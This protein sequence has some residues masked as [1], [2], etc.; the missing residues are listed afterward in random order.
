MFDQVMGL[1]DSP[2]RDVGH[3][4]DTDDILEAPYQSCPR[5][6]D[7]LAQRCERPVEL[8]LF[9]DQRERTVNATITKCCHEPGRRFVVLDQ[10]IQK[11][12]EQH[13][14]QSI[15]NATA[16]RLRA[17][18]FQVNQFHDRPY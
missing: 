8:R 18:H 2:V 12:Q 16:C 3:R 7:T 6:A 14:S 1:H 15:R 17:L 4:S 11:L 9:V 13:F 5:H 10:L